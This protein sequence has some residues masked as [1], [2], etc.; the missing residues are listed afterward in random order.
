MAYLVNKVDTQTKYLVDYMR[1][2]FHMDAKVMRYRY[3]NDGSD[4]DSDGLRQLKRKFAPID[5][6]KLNSWERT[7][8]ES[9][10]M[11]G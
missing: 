9:I 10:D 6:I 2:R 8:I 4:L 11:S 5:V 7:D 3:V 1:W